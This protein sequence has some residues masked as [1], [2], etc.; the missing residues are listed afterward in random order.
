MSTIA[1]T[2]SLGREACSLN[3]NAW[4]LSSN[5]SA[6]TPPRRAVDGLNVGHADWT[7]LPPTDRSLH[8][9]GQTGHRGPERHHHPTLIAVIVRGSHRT[10]S[11]SELARLV[12]PQAAG[13]IRANQH[14]WGIEQVSTRDTQSGLARVCRAGCPTRQPRAIGRSLISR[15]EWLAVLTSC[16][17]GNHRWVPLAGGTRSMTAG[18]AFRAPAIQTMVIPAART[19]R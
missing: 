4:G 14:G 18:R 19:M 6:A 7:G 13:R 10:G 11:W 5:D 12:N 1:L 16:P 3:A 15:R 2:F 9:T 17:N 8:G